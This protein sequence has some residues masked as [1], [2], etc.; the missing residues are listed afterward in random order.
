M[1]MRMWSQ[2][3]IIVLNIWGKQQKDFNDG[4]SGLDKEKLLQVSSDGPNVNLKFLKNLA[5]ERKNDEMTQLIDIGTCGLHTIHN[6]FKHGSVGSKWKIQ[7]LLHSMYKIFHESPS[8]RAD[9]ERL[10]S[11]SE[12]NYPLQF[13]WHRWIEHADVAKMAIIVWPKLWK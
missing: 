13:V 6:S 4:V 8:R 12:Q 11:A 7:N 3:D 9:F 10:T 1:T 2:P 5:E